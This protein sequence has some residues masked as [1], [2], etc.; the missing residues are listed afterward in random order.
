MMN[1]SAGQQYSGP[2]CAKKLGAPVSADLITIYRSA[3]VQAEIERLRI[4]RS[5]AEAEVRRLDRTYETTLATNRDEA[6]CEH[7]NAIAKERRA[8]RRLTLH[9][10]VLEAELLRREEHEQRMRNL[11]FG[12]TQ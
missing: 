11:S 12:A 9:L 1:R 2:S 5:C 3:D 7:L 10:A 8:I 4:E 6:A